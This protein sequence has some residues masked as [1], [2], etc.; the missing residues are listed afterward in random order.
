MQH[1]L[2]SGTATY[3][4]LTNGYAV[5]R[6]APAH[7]PIVAAQQCRNCTG[8][9]AARLGGGPREDRMMTRH[10]EERLVLSMLTGTGIACVVLTTLFATVLVGKAF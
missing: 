6:L 7:Q 10:L 3:R 2:F 4:I 8:C 1:S 5:F 9:A